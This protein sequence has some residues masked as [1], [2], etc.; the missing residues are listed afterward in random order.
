MQAQVEYRLIRRV[1]EFAGFLEEADLK[2]RHLL[3]L[4]L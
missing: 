3:V 1:E 4:R 2:S